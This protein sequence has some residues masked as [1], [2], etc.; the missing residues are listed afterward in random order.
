MIQVPLLTQR[1]ALKTMVDGWFTDPSLAEVEA[2]HAIYAREITLRK[3]WAY[4][5]MLKLCIFDLLRASSHLHLLAK[6]QKHAQIRLL[7][8][9]QR[10]TDF[11]SA[12]IRPYARTSNATS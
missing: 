3:Y 1:V 12:A 2:L 11:A 5:A 9:L 4:I 8:Q 6:A 10:S 7:Q